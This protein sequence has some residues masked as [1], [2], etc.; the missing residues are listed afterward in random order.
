MVSEIR[1]HVMNQ[2]KQGEMPEGTR[3]TASWYLDA[4][5]LAVV[6]HSLADYVFEQGGQ[7][8]LDLGC[9]LGGYSK[10]LADRGRKLIALDV[11]EKYV[12]IAKKLGVDARHYDGRKIPLPDNAVDTIFMIEVMEHIPNPE[13][14]LSE[15]RRVARK[16]IIVTVPNCTQTFKSPV[17]FTHM[18]DVD[19]RNFFTQESLRELLSR[20]FHD[21]QVTQVVPVDRDLAAELLPR[22]AFR[23]WR[24]AYK[25][26]LLKD[27]YYFRLLA[28]A[29]V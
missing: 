14:L 20:E 28:N 23:A 1:M 3:D 4:D 22:W 25:R 6:D 10:T 18:L 2:A 19:H 24:F 21:V 12:E 11:N 17:T 9:G 8:L 7:E 13:N 16:N 15:L 26:G 27:R 29:M 5:P